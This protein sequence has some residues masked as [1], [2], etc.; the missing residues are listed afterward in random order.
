MDTVDFQEIDLL[1][2]RWSSW[3]EK[4]RIIR[5]VSIESDVYYRLEYVLSMV[6]NSLSLSPAMIAEETILGSFK[7]LFSMVFHKILVK[8]FW[9]YLNFENISESCSRNLV[10][11][12]IH[13]FCRECTGGNICLFRHTSCSTSMWSKDDLL[14]ICQRF[15]RLC[16]SCYTHSNVNDQK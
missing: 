5:L 13:R 6:R 14:F 12:S 7:I 4:L 1:I 3:P 2:E 10:T 11:E 8:K 9:I 15:C 16:R